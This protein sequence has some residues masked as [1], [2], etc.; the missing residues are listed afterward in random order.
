MVIAFLIEKNKELFYDMDMLEKTKA[1]F[2]KRF[3]EEKM[4][5]STASSE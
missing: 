5:G 1:D 3:A 4:K 2:E